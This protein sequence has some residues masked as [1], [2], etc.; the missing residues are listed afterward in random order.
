MQ[1]HFIVFAACF[2]QLR[3]VGA[4]ALAGLGVVISWLMTA[5]LKSR[6]MPVFLLLAAAC[7]VIALLQCGALAL[8]HTSS[9]RWYEV[10]WL[11]LRGAFGAMSNIAATMAS[12][13]GAPLGDVA[14]LQSSNVLAAAVLG[15]AFL[16]EPLNVKHLAVLS[17][18]TLGAV[19]ISRPEFIFSDSSEAETKQWLGYA[20]ALGGGFCRALQYMSSRKLKG[21]PTLY[22]CLSAITMRGLLCLMLSCSTLAGGVSTDHAH[23]FSW[24]ALG[25]IGL[26]SAVTFITNFAQSSGAQRCKAIVSATTY[27]AVTMVGGYI[28]QVMLYGKVP[29]SITITGAKLMF[30]SILIMG[31]A[32]S[33]VIEVRTP[34]KSSLPPKT[35]EVA[36]SCT[37][38]NKA[39]WKYV[40]STLPR[41]STAARRMTTKR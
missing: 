18:S 34:G 6:N 29:S 25:W 38:I 12:H 26:F 32:Q 17:F 21:T 33:P 16:G 31:W 5:E 11:L 13:L 3:D 28:A 37:S 19:L 1:R 2:C 20:L 27:Q 35:I 4:I 40:A 7:G 36:G 8:A 15:W 22:S 10:K 30:V 39:K 41:L 24:H 9:P 23:V 14:A